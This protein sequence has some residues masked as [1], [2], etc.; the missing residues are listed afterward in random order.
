MFSDQNKPFTLISFKHIITEP[1]P[2]IPWIVEPFLAEGDRLLLFGEYRSLKSWILPHLGLHLAAGKDW[3]R[4]F[5]IPQPKSVLYVDEEMSEWAIR[6]RVKQLAMG[7]GIED[8]GLPFNVLSK[9]G[10]TFDA[11]GAET[12]LRNLQQVHFEPKIII[13]ET[14]RRVMEGDEKEAQHVNRFW[15]HVSP[16]LDAGTTLIV[17]HHMRKANPK[18]KESV[19]DRASGS[20]DIMAGLD[21][22]IG[23]IRNNKSLPLVTLHHVKD[24]ATKEHEPFSIRL[25]VEGDEGPARLLY[26]AATSSA[27]AAGSEL[28]R[29]MDLCKEYFGDKGTQVIK[30]KDV[31]G[32]LT[33]KNMKARTAEAAFKMF[34]DTGEVVS[35]KKGH[36]QKKPLQEIAA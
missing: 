4:E 33:N 34:Q 15:K 29:G 13:V 6:R 31:I 14:L 23:I 36:W 35:I 27:Q 25:E 22:A 16:I 1:L 24:R 11:D 26:E 5:S 7:A 19:A 3:F 8:E 18:S 30:T 12:L 17:S 20:I 21:S 2:P 28:E 32:F 10:V 9:W